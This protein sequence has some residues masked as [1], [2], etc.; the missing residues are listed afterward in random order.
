[1]VIEILKDFQAVDREEKDTHI[2]S[3]R[4]KKLH[5]FSITELGRGLLQSVA[6]K[7]F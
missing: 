2:G 7:P 5:A 4:F 1:M 3:Y 6:S